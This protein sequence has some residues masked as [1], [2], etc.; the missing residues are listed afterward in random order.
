MSNSTYILDDTLL[1]STGKRFLNYIIDIIVF[2]IA[3]YSF[4]IVLGILIALG[5][6]SIREWMSGL[7]DLGWNLVGIVML[8]SYYTLTEGFLGRSVGKLITG[9]IV[10]DENG[11]KI[12]FGSAFKRSLCRLIPFDGLSFLGS[13]GW[14]DSITETYVVEKKSLDESLKLFKD[15]QLIGVQEAEV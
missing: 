3:M 11:E 10:V 14:H 15:F 1:A 8:V 2:L 6:E 7:G 4:G 13:R 12:N 5:M 9:T